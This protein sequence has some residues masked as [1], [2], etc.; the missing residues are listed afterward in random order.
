MAVTRTRGYFERVLG[1]A[2]VKLW[3]DLPR[4]IQQTI[5]EETVIGGHLTER[6]ESLR[7]QLAEYLHTA[8]QEE[9][10]HLTTVVPDPAPF[11]RSR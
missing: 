11:D 2:V 10:V 4:D 9:G 7:E 3:G 1:R 6:D 8:H 5:F